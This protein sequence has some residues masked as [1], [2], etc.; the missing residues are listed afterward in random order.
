MY[1]VRADNVHYRDG[2][3]TTPLQPNGGRTHLQACGKMRMPRTGSLLIDMCYRYDCHTP[4][5]QSNGRRTHLLNTAGC[6]VSP[7][8]WWDAHDTRYAERKV[9]I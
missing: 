7:S 6:V 9:F 5:P 8:M 2:F 3:C 1:C 4:P